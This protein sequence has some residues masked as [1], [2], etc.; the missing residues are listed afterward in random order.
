[1]KKYLIA[2]GIVALLLVSSCSKTRNCRCTAE[3]ENAQEPVTIVNVDRGMKCS[4]ITRVGFERQSGD[5]LVRT[6]ENVTC[7]EE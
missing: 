7:E 6:L 1:M 5:Q 4:S 2:V 3:N